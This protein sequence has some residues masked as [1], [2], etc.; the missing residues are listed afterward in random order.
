MVL[1]FCYQNHHLE[2]AKINLY[3][4]VNFENNFLSKTDCEEVC[5]VLEN[6]C[7]NGLPAMGPE[8][9]P[10]LCTSNTAATACGAGYYCHF[11][12]T[13]STT[14]CCPASKRLLFIHVFCVFLA[15]PKKIFNRCE[16]LH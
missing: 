12:A 14:V 1:L 9:N 5:P 6:P 8:G 4:S 2:L 16:E 15:S 10:I 7:E 11:G 13:P 3:S